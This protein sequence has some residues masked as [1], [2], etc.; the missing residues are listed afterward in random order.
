MAGAAYGRN[1]PAAY[2]VGPARAGCVSGLGDVQG[3]AV[4]GIH[5]AWSEPAVLRSFT[6]GICVLRSLAP[7]C[8]NIT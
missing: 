3:R 6:A 8:N 2:V 5:F 7:V 4:Q 1:V